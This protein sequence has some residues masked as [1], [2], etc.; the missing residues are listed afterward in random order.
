MFNVENFT[1]A[2]DKKDSLTRKLVGYSG[3]NYLDPI[4]NPDGVRKDLLTR[5][6]VDFAWENYL[7]N[8]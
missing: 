4:R 7:V 8:S 6:P 5:D 1:Y 2:W 3:D